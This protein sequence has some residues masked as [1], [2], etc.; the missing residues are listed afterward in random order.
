[1]M[2]MFMMMTVNIIY[3]QKNFSV[4]IYICMRKKGMNMLNLINSI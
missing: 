2:T 1:M 3:I 4:Y